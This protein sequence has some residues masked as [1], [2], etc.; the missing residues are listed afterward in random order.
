MTYAAAIA[1]LKV[2]ATTAGAALPNPITDV[3][4][5]FP[6]PKGRCIRIFYGGE[7]PADLLGADSSQVSVMVGH[8]TIVM[9]FWPLSNL[10]EGNAAVIEAE[11]AAFV[12]GFRTAVLGDVGL[13]TAVHALELEHAEPGFADLAGTP[14]R[15]VEIRVN[16]EYTEYSVTR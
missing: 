12:D 16:T 15:T 9:G 8:Q 4:I 10:S 1:R 5:A 6:A 11:V 7:T 14:W 2:H 13:A 3:A